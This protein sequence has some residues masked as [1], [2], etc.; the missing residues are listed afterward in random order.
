MRI[1][2]LVVVGALLLVTPP[3]APAAQGSTGAGMAEA[4]HHFYSARY[5]DAAAVAQTLLAARPDDLALLELRT[6]A[7]HFQMRREL[8][9]ARDKKAAFARCQACS[10]LLATFTADVRRARA[11]ARARLDAGPADTEAL[12]FLGKIDLNYIWMQ[13]G[14]LGRRTGWDEYWEARRSLDALL[15]AEPEHVRGRVARAW[16]DYI[17]NT[18]VPWGTRWMVGGGNK[19]RALA[20]VREAAATD[21]GTYAA[22]EAE[23]GLLEMLSREGRHAEAVMIA[24]HLLVR[25]PENQDLVRL[26]DA[27]AP[28]I[29]R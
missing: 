22:V 6:S 13:L 15:K 1:S 12:F 4:E 14:T 5:L 11:I 8:G 23:F 2:A 9:D 25:F 17:V 19:T 29:D 3:A 28:S 20:A 26:I 27:N 10:E 21:T 16:I 18:K 24:R 7:L